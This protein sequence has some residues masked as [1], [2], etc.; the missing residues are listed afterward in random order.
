[1][2]NQTVNIKFEKARR[3]LEKLAGTKAYRDAA[4]IARARL[5]RGDDPL[6]VVVYEITDV[7]LSRPMPD[8]HYDDAINSVTAYM[9]GAG[10]ENRV[11]DAW[12]ALGRDDAWRQHDLA[13][14][15]LHR[16]VW[17]NNLSPRGAAELW[18]ENM[19]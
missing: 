12:E 17:R 6:S 5:W 1:M 15:L 9:L 8:S 10:F 18:Q 14:A 19:L 4:D 3:M 7:V 16:M 13:K 11:L 2:D